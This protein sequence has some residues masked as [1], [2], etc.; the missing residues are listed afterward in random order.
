MK[1]KIIKIGNSKGIRIPNELIKKYKL[2]QEVTLELKEDSIVLK[3]AEVDPRA[4]WEEIYKK[5]DHTLTQEEKDWMDFGN[6]FDK[7]EWTW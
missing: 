7:E 1:A 5:M 3:P 6:E 4:R 2:D